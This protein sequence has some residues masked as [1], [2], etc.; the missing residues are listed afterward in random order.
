MA[1]NVKSIK[2]GAVLFRAGDPADGMYLV[3]KG[4]L[5]VYLE[6]NGTEV[7]LA[8]VGAGNMIGEM[9][10]FDKKPRSASVKANEDTEITIITNADR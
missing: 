1:G 10:F 6:Q 3:R 8:N 7:K 2:A 9:A 5:M 4:E